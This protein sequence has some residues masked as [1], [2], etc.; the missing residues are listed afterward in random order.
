MSSVVSPL[1]ASVSYRR[2]AGLILLA[3]LQLAAL[4]LLVWFEDD[5]VA[6][7]AFLLFW[8]LLNGF[9]LILIRRPAPAAA[10]SLAL[11]ALLIEL[12]RFKHRVLLMT[13]TFTDLM[14]IDSDTS[15]FLLTIWPEL[16]WMAAV[17]LAA[18]LPALGLLWWLDPVRVKRSV[19]V[20][21]FALC[22][23]ALAGLSLTLPLDREDEFA[24]HNFVSKFARSGAVAMI[25]LAQHGVL[26][27][28]A[29][30]LGHIDP[31]AIG[32]CRP[33]APLPNIILI[34]DES[35]FD[36]S[37]LPG[38][39]VPADYQAHF[40]SLDGKTRH[41]IVEG[42]GGP[43]WFTE[44]NVLTGL[45]VRSYGRFAEAATRL[46]NG[47]VARG[48]AHA[49]RRCGYRTATVYPYLGGFLG[50]RSFQA[51]AGIEDFYDAKTLG[52]RDRQTDGFY[53]DFVMR[54][55]E[56]DRS[57]NPKFFF[58]YTSAN[59]F[60]WDFRYR[61]DLLPQWRPAGNAAAVDEY[62][63]RQALS[64][65]DYAAFVARLK[66]AFP[67][68]PFLLVRFGDH[69]PLFAKYLV[70][71]GLDE[72][73]VA[74]RIDHFDPRY[75]T[76][77]YAIDAIN[78]APADVALALDPLDAPYLPLVVLEAAGVPLDAS[79]AEQ[80]AILQRCSGLFYLCNDGA[81]ARR[82][83]RLLIDAGMIKGL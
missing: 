2:A 31:A 78:F 4:A 19:A 50:A 5:G 45:S 75:F 57:R 58:V 41:F 23:A 63:R 72:A 56:G 15:S 38:I 79:F 33:A 27:S 69:Q 51:T 25:D 29:V 22:F 32:D 18:G 53:Y 67:G 74:Q 52:S 70:E 21:A 61:P 59:H 35:S 65:Q 34:F 9:W 36:I 64:A 7:L 8:G 66:Q 1:R 44:Y 30:A 47:H 13:I 12:S 83:N 3:L 28:D 76:T 39:R 48:L 6:R 80:R 40:R 55:L 17:A 82:F 71:P 43:S 20:T 26:E 77:Y 49:L 68:Q 10:L 46:A 81:E 42:A 24:G 54:T 14:V 60:P 16:K 62:I 37:A 11:L 73:G